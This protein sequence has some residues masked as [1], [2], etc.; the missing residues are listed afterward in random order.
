MGNLSIQVA[1]LLLNM[2]PGCVITSAVIYLAQIM[3]LQSP[4]TSHPIK[5]S[6]DGNTCGNVARDIILGLKRKNETANK[7][8][9]LTH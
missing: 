6:T 5:Q 7:C 3:R 1:L 8:T 2:P 9:F 4:A